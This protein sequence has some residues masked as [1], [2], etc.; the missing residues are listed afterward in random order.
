MANPPPPGPPARSSKR[1][2]SAD[3]GTTG[4][5]VGLQVIASAGG[6][7]A[8]PSLVSIIVGAE[9]ANGRTDQGA[10]AL[11]RGPVGSRTV[12]KGL[13]ISDLGDFVDQPVVAV[14]ATYR[15]DGTVLL[16]PVWHEY[17][18][19]GFNVCTSKSDVKARHVRRDPRASLVIAEQRPPYRG[20]ELTAQATL[21]E[22]ELA[23]TVRRIAVR[24]LGEEMGGTYAGS[25]PDD[26]VIRLE[27]GEIR[28][29]DF[30]DDF[31]S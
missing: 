24:Y 2:S 26:I 11:G 16:S 18:Q 17:R 21:T 8:L 12:R 25:A 19:G 9:G 29:W 23:A 30:A 31:P 22:D 1:L 13:G 10:T 3:V 6:N 15:N 7:A 28:A 4:R 27:P 5:T 14:L 20:I